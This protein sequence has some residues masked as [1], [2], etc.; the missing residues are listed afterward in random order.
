MGSW[1]R[2]AKSNRQKYR[3]FTLYFA[4]NRGNSR[5][6][7]FNKEENGIA[8]VGESKKLAS[9]VEFQHKEERFMRYM[10][11]RYK[12]NIFS[13]EW[14]KDCEM[15][16][17]VNNLRFHLL[18]QML[19]WKII[20]YFSRLALWFRGI[21]FFFPFEKERK[22]QKRRDGWIYFIN[23]WYNILKAWGKII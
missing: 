5:M 3:K 9:S 18:Q 20:S 13:D 1:F 10:R 23:D 21:R 7:I 19:R 16:E 11:V 15:W 8:S 12:G 2:F 4:V 6:A 14:K 22:N 17:K